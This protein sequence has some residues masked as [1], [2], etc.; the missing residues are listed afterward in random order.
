VAIALRQPGSTMKPFTYSAALEAGVMTPGSVI[1]DTQT[2]IGIPGQPQYVPRNYDGA[3][4]GPMTMRFALGNSYNIPAVQTLRQVGVDYLLGIMRRFGVT[5][6]GGDSSQYGLSLTLGGGEVSLLELTNAYSVFANGGTYV[7]PTAIRCVLDNE[8]NIVYQYEDS[9]PRGTLTA[10]TIQRRG[11]GRTVLD[12]RIAFIM[13]NIL[14]DNRAR[15][16]AMGL[17]SPLFTGNIPTAVKTGTT[18]DVKDNWTIGYTRNV[19]VG[20]WV[21][22]NDGQ[23]MVNTSGLTGAAPIWNSVITTIYNSPGLLNAFADGSGQLVPDDFQNPPAN[24]TGLELR[25]IC[26]VRSLRGD[27]RSLRD[28]A[29]DCSRINEWFLNSPAGIPDVDGNLIYGQAAP[30]PQPATTG[31]LLQEVSPGV[32]Q[33]L[34][35]KLAPEIANLIQFNIPPGQQPPPAP[36]YCLVPQEIAGSAAGAQPQLFI[37]PPPVPDDAVAAENYARQ[38]GLAFL[39]TVACSPDLLQG[40]GFVANSGVAVGVVQSPGAGAV[41][42]G[43]VQII[44]TAQFPTGGGQFYKFQIIGYKFQIIGGPFPEWQDF[45]NQHFD[46][47]VNGYMLENVPV[48]VLPNGD[49]R[50]RLIVADG[51]GNPLLPPYEVPFGV[52]R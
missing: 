2:S 51:G 40:G 44:G 3:F 43:E 32:Y 8:D 25:Q 47:V 23:P 30:P 7:G 19:A 13:D 28:P 20:V 35:F 45:G 6:L 39:P 22:N 46:N 5:T 38:Q 15:A 9:C 33:V 27:V 34:A 29:T 36:I 18:N 4:H 26:D 42:N 10:E 17:N 49:Y 37:A 31:P 12:P 50:L 24:A 41:L 11:Y 16:S 52:S 1:W 48:G 21:G 14:S